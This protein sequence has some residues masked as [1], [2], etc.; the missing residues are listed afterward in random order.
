MRPLSITLEGFSAY[1]N[2]QT[3]GLEEVEFFPPGRESRA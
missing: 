1:R 3:V 2:R